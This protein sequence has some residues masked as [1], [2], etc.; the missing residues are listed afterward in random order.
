M[1]ILPFSLSPSPEQLGKKSVY[2]MER[3]FRFSGCP[4][5]F[6]LFH[7]PLIFH[8][9]IWNTVLYRV[10]A[11]S[12]LFP[13]A[14]PFLSTHVWYHFW[15]NQLL[16]LIFARFSMVRARGA[17]SRLLFLTRAKNFKKLFISVVNV[18]KWKKKHTLK[19]LPDSWM[20]LIES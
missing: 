12:P 14:I 16:A 8:I 2:A 11:R 10:V 6:I 19:C 18:V 3:Y 9:I 17:L 4:F 5:L 20:L 15:T 7:L 1:K 13:V